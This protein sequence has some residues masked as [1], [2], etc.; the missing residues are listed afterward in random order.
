MTTTTSSA[1]VVSLLQRDFEKDD[2]SYF[3]TVEKAFLN[4]DAAIEYRDQFGLYEAWITKV[5]LV[6]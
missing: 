3:V 5:E 4:Q 1:W 6:P 2:G